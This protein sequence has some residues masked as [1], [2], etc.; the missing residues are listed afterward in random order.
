VGDDGGMPNATRVP[1]TQLSQV[2]HVGCEQHIR[3]RDWAVISFPFYS[4]APPTSLQ[5]SSTPRTL[6]FT[7]AA[8]SSSLLSSNGPYL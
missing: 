2:H 5:H 1:T 4:P 7:I 8:K 3:T 6:V